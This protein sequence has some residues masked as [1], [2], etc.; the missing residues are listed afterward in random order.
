MPSVDHRRTPSRN[1][2]VPSSWF[3]VLTVGACLASVAV[4]GWL[5]VEGDAS[6]EVATPPSATATTTA[7]EPTDTADP[8]PTPTPT[9]TP[10]ASEPEPAVA[11]DTPVSVLNNTGVAGAATT[12]ATK[13]E[14]AGWTVG[15]VGNWRGSIGENTV[16]YP[17]GLQDQ[18]QQLANDVGITRVKP[19]VDNMRTDRLTI[20]LSGPQ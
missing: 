18:A 12:F 7:P 20:I 10:T 13:V 9:E 17:A 15:G 19:A 11:R 4:I 3:V 5:L 14:S 1:L 8:T 16:Y 6:T 2:F